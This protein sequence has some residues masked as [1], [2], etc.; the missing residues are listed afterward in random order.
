MLI[1]LLLVSYTRVTV[2]SKLENDIGRML[3]NT[4]EESQD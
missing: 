4:I 3:A 1:I 2:N